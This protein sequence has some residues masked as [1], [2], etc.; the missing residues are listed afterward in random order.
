MSFEDPHSKM[1]PD[2]ASGRAPE[3]TNLPVAE[4]PEEQ[5]ASLTARLDTVEQ[6]RRELEDR[7]LRA[8]ADLDNFRKRV[9]R[10]QAEAA[11]YAVEPLARELLAVVDNLERALEHAGGDGGTAPLVEGV[12]LVLRSLDEVLRRH[13][14]TVVEAEPGQPF[15]P[16]RHEA[17]ERREGAGEPNRIVQVWEKGYAMHE[18]LLRPARVSVSAAPAAHVANRSDDD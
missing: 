5:I 14:V 10:E 8:V 11:R 4:S 9:R 6:E 15:D 1:A 2:P 18:R 7:H 3:A 17:V 12:S 16:N 13:G